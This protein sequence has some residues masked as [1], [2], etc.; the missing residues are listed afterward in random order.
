MWLFVA[1]LGFE[2]TPEFVNAMPN[3]DAAISHIFSQIPKG[4]V[5]SRN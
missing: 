5:G 2:P 4:A 3:E 1:L